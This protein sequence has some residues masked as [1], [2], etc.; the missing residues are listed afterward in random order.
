[1]VELSYISQ[2]HNP[3]GGITHSVLDSS[4]PVLQIV[5]LLLA[6]IP[7]GQSDVG[8]ASKEVPSF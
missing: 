4:I 3:R 6:Q 1:M 8:N 7:T 2:D 5:P